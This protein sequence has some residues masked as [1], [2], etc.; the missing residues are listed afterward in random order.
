MISS[1]LS[2]VRVA[3]K[4]ISRRLGGEGSV[5]VP[6]DGIGGMLM[7]N[8]RL[9]FAAGLTVCG[10]AGTWARRVAARRSGTSI[11][12]LPFQGDSK[13]TVTAK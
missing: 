4:G 11:G 2:R 8:E 7:V 9:V 3:F 10:E 13:S 6:N 12:K 5:S 1:G